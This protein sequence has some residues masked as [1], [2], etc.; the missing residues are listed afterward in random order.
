[1]KKRIIFTIITILWMSIIFIFSNQKSTVSTNNSQSFIKETIGNVY[2][3]INQNATDEKVQEVV[4]FFDVPIRK[5]AHFTEYFIL[6][7]LIFLTFKSYGINNWKYMLLFCF[8]YAYSDELHQLFVLGRSCSFFDVLL[9]TFG[10][11][12]SIFLFNK[13]M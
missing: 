13:K 2:R 4:N 1:M 9:D 3:L 11:F 12:V 10:S 7:L 6:G 5:L 8:L